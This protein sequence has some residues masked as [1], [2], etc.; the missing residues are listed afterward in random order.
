MKYKGKAYTFDDIQLLP[1]YND[2]ESRTEPDLTSWFTA[3]LEIG[4]PIVN[5]P[6]DCVIDLTMAERLRDLG[7]IPI[8][9][10]YQKD[11]GEVLRCYDG[12]CFVSIGVHEKDV[13]QLLR[14]QE[15]F[16]DK[17]LGVVIDVAHGHSSLM[18]KQITRIKDWDTGLKII[19]GSV[20]HKE[21]YQ[22]LA[23]AGSDA[24]RVGIGPGSACTTRGVTGHGV[25]QFS[26]ILDC[27]EAAM[28]KRIPIIADGGIRC[29]ADI[30][31]AL[32]A[33][34]SSVMIGK[35]L[36]ACEES[37]AEKRGGRP[38]EV[39]FLPDL[40]DRPVTTGA[41]VLGKWWGRTRPAQVHVGPRE[42][43]YRGQASEEYQIDQCGGLKPG[44]VP[45]GIEGWVPVTG[46]V[47]GLFNSLLGGLRS[48]MTYGGARNIKE[49][50]RKAEFVSVEGGALR[51][52]G[53]RLNGS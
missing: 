35:L 21:A 49:L 11:L 50:Q 46:S 7:S 13:D 4:V 12:K 20:C 3:G 27:G 41:A 29:S 52:A 23:G 47:E 9:H 1:Q 18:E 33:G 45:E 38:G 8:F 44:T 16:P 32:A 39:M 42:A 15:K 37:P 28:K 24:V 22:D 14:V 26:A 30:V 17:I 31:K 19:S 34:A 6:M 43:R 2:I 53:T 36:A 25:P 48:G 10:K 51:E 40:P 5:S